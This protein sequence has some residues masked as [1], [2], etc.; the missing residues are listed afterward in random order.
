MSKKEPFNSLE[1]SRNYHS[2]P[3]VKERRKLRNE[4][5]DVK[6]K[7]K[8]ASKLWTEKNKDRVENTRLLRKFNIT[9]KDYN[10]MFE[11]QQGCCAICKKH[12]LEF[13]TKLHVDHC[14]ITGKVRG[15]LCYNCNRAL[16][17]FQDDLTV[18]KESVNYLNT[19]GIRR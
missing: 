19:N 3:E 18:L 16:G 14:H 6:E 7:H 8:Q 17:L 13:K 10:K 12:Q 1:W 4:R 15:L 2:K 9:L 11:G 5:P